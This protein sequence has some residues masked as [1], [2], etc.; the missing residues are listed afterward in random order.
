MNL[1]S[2]LISSKSMYT[3]PSQHIV[4]DMFCTRFGQCEVNVNSLSK[5]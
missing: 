4:I 1:H 5:L 2:L 3:P